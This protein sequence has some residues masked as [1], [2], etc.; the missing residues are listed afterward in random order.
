MAIQTYLVNN[1]Q[2]QYIVNGTS[3]TTCSLEHR[4]RQHI[5][6]RFYRFRS[7]G[8]DEIHSIRI[9]SVNFVLYDAMRCVCMNSN[10]LSMSVLGVWQR[11][12]GILCTQHF[13]VFLFS[14]SLSPSFSIS[15]C[16]RKCG[17]TSWR[18]VGQYMRWWMGSRWG[19]SYMSTTWFYWIW[20]NYA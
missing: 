7:N 6:A 4:L 13:S 14:I 12:F 8:Y 10:L 19:S 20:E 15:V 11:Q 16:H 17:N 2:Q 9:S 5:G 1:I 18:K 3:M